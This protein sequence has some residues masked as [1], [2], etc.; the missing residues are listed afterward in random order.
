MH[1]T[2]IDSR[3]LGSLFSTPEMK[4]V[5][6][7]SSTLA[8]YTETE[9]ALALAEGKLGL[10]PTDAAKTIASVGIKPNLPSAKAKATS[11]SV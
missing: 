6:S 2:L 10:I 7:D 8:C 4:N 1:S 9:V 3:F 11:V 5:F